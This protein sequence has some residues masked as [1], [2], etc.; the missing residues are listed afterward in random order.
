MPYKTV[1]FGGPQN[2]NEEQSCLEQNKGDEII[3]NGKTAAM[4]VMKSALE[5]N[6]KQGY[7]K[8]KGLNLSHSAQAWARLSGDEQSTS[9]EYAKQK[10]GAQI[11]NNPNPFT[12]PELRQAKV[13]LLGE[14]HMRAYPAQAMAENLAAFNKSA[15]QNEKITH[16]FLEFHVKS[17]VFADFIKQNINK[18]PEKEFLA[19]LKNFVDKT[20]IKG[21]TLREKM[22]W[23]YIMYTVIKNDPS[24]QVFA[25]DAPGNVAQ[26]NEIAASYIEAASK[27][28]GSK[29]VF[30]TGAGH[31]I[32]SDVENSES[33]S[34]YDAGYSIAALAKNYYP[35]NQIVSA[36]M[37]GGVEWTEDA[38]LYGAAKTGLTY[39][40]DFSD[41]IM[42]NARNRTNSNFILK[43]DPQR[44]G[45]DFFFHF[46]Q[47]AEPAVTDAAIW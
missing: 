31:I 7:K 14:N 39:A 2:Y 38:A 4:S 40:V 44:D 42:K 37:I 47:S 24:V 27:V 12:L 35:E 41:Y 11:I 34:R 17:N 6:S 8:D 23:A 30:M 33:L 29:I 25:Y 5:E 45:F 19:D 46:N 15:A 9:N 1:I 21:A 43:T 13:I 28:P 26:R 10:S 18:T 22:R 20:D 36:Y 3:E 32:K 16:L